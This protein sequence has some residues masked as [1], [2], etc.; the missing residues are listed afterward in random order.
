M[1]KGGKFK[2]KEEE[3]AE[4][5]KVLVKMKTQ[6]DIKKTTIEEEEKKVVALVEESKQVFSCPD[7]V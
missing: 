6:S 5:E 1:R 4:L 7:K 3:V 2:K